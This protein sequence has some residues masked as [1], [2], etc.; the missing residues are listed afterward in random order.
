TIDDRRFNI[1]LALAGQRPYT[2]IKLREL[3]N[4]ICGEGNYRI[5]EDYKNY[6]VHFKVSL[7]VKKQRD[8]VS[9]LLRD[10]IPMNLIYDV[11]L[12]YNRHIDLARYTHKELAQF[13]HFVLNQEVLPK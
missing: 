6:N 11:D 8:A 4:G 13:T 10:L 5:V 2:E 7:G 1:L 9:K 3:L 12:L